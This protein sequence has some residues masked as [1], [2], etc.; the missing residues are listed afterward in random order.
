MS[1][2]RTATLHWCL[3]HYSVQHNAYSTKPLGPPGGLQGRACGLL[4]CPVG[5][6]AAP[7]W[8]PRG[9]AG[10]LLGAPE[11]LASSQTTL[12]P[13]PWALGP[14]NEGTLTK[15]AFCKVLGSLGDPWG[16]LGV[17]RAPLKPSWMPPGP[18]N[19]QP[20]L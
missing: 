18:P 17:P 6:P 14:N 16:A 13:P 10:A 8:L 19:W 7:P 15:R 1:G 12:A 11:L 3:S 5:E 20:K 4:G 2:E 9:S